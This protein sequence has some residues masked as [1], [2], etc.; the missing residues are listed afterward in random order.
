MTPS[1]LSRTE[2]LSLFTLS[3]ACCG[4][5]ANVFQGDGNPVAASLALSGL[6]LSSTYSLIRWLGPTFIKSNLKGRD[7]SKLKKV[8]MYV[9]IQLLQ[10]YQLTCCMTDRN[11][12]EQYAPLYIFFASSPLSPFHSTRISWLLHQVEE[13]ETWSYKSNK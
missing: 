4:V 3:I 1:K 6:G 8:E 2:T 11:V 9:F 7:M 5:L 10:E 13:T 12:W